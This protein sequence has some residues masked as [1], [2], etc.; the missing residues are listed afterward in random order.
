MSGPFRDPT[1][2]VREQGLAL[3]QDVE[4]RRASVAGLQEDLAVA[5]RSEAALSNDRRRAQIISAISGFV[6]GALVMSIAVLR[7]C[8]VARRS[9]APAPARTQVRGDQPT[10]P[11]PSRSAA[12]AR[13]L[14]SV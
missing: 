6:L 10:M 8:E 13:G 12:R 9:A 3:Q 4:R 14:S 2:A 7:N 11:K 1:E 5:R